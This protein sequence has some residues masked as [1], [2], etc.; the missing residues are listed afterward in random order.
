MWIHFQQQV[1]EQPNTYQQ[2]ELTTNT[3]V[4]PQEYEVAIIEN[5]TTESSER[6]VL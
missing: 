5:P 1:E 3:G 6:L 2:Y 4:E